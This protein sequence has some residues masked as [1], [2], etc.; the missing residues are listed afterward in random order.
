MDLAQILKHL[1][2]EEI[3][4]ITHFSN[5]ISRQQSICER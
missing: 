4:D 3:S 1:F 5:L 2:L